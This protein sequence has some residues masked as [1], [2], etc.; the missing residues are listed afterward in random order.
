MSYDRLHLRAVHEVP[1]PSPSTELSC[2]T[3]LSEVLIVRVLAGGQ[4]LSPLSSPS[5]Q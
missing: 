3:G 5:A 1:L 2:Y 4:L